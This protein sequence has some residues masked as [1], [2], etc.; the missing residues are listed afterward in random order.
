MYKHIPANPL[1]RYRC[2]PKVELVD[3]MIGNLRLVPPQ[4]RLENAWCDS[5][6]AYGEFLQGKFGGKEFGKVSCTGFGGIIRKL[7]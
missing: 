5:T 1:Q 3:D 6:N 2:D 7:G 4:F